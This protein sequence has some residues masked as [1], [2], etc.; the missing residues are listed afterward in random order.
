MKIDLKFARSISK[1]YREKLE[2][3]LD[4]ILEQ[5]ITE[6][7]PPSLDFNGWYYNSHIANLQREYDDRDEA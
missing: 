6:N 5:G 2:K 7:R 4:K 3:F 1:A